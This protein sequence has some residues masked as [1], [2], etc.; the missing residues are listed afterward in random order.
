MRKLFLAFLFLGALVFFLPHFLSLNVLKQQ[1]EKRLSSQLGGEVQIEKI[2]LSWLS[3][4]RADNVTWHHPKKGL[5]VLAETITLQENLME[6][7]RSQEK[8]LHLEVT[9]ASMQTQGD[10]RFIRKMRGKNLSLKF[11]PILAKVQNGVIEVERT[12]IAINEKMQ[13]TTQGVLDFSK[14]RIDILL[15][16]KQETLQKVFKEARNLPEDFVLEIPIQTDMSGKS[17]EKALLGY[18][19][20]NYARVTSLHK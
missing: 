10:F 20:R 6:C 8:P 5:S 4:Q 18:F 13:I 11:S 2:S 9:G 3:T 17:I 19:I 12:Q 14:S 1:V 15:G 16:L 7:L